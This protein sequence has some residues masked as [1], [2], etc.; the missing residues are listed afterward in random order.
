MPRQSWIQ[1]NGELIPKD[2]YV[3]PVKSGLQIIP[4]IKPYQS[5]ITGEEIGSRSKHRAHLKRHGM[6]EVGNEFIPPK[7]MPDV[8]GLKDDILR[9]MR[10]Y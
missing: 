8:P 5:V 2:Q 9:A 3:E 10:G 4:D 6:I 7:K 1:I